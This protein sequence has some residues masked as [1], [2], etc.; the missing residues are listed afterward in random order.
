MLCNSIWEWREENT[1]ENINFANDKKKQSLKLRSFDDE[2]WNNKLLQESFLWVKGVE[3]REI[4]KNWD[5]FLILCRRFFFYCSSLCLKAQSLFSFVGGANEENTKKSWIQTLFWLQRK[6][7]LMEKMFL[8]SQ[9]FFIQESF[10]M[11][12]LI[13]HWKRKGFVLLA[14]TRDWGKWKERKL[15]KFVKAF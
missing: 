14:E 6:R 11:V 3:R 7:F 12:V 10:F 2:K 15:M 5:I 1:K 13:R 4:R 8:N 9:T